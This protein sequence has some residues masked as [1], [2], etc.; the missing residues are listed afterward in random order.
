[1][2]PTGGSLPAELLA[3]PYGFVVVIAVCAFWGLREW[4]KGREIDVVNYRR[5]AED[6]EA[7]ADLAEGKADTDISVLN[8]K[9]EQLHGEIRLL[10]DQHFREL[11]STTAK[12]YAA[13]QMLMFKGVPKEDIP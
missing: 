11:E 13:R 6:A 3:G 8:T 5:R 10:R 2:D 9:V 1:M 12:Y 7:R 4:R